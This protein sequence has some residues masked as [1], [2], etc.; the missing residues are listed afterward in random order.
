M[1]LQKLRSRWVILLAVVGLFALSGIALAAAD[2]DTVFNYGYD[3]DSQFFAWN[4]TSLDWEPDYAALA[5]ELGLETPFDALEELCGLQDSE[6]APVEYT[7]DFNGATGGITV[8]V[9]GGPI[10]CGDFQGGYVTG[11]SGQVNH[12]MFLKLFNS[13]YDGPHRGCLVRHIA[14]SE[15]GKDDQKVQADPEF[16]TPEEIE[17]IDDGRITFKTVGA[18]CLKGT[19]RNGLEEEDGD[20]RGPPDHVVEKKAEKQAEKAEKWGESGPGKSGSHRP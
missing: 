4:V 10:D 13:I 1:D 16:E 11:P 8:E 12:G 19:D 3:Q 9:E 18:D 5:E 7:Y 14:G 15:L 2:E 17:S 6:A 20:R